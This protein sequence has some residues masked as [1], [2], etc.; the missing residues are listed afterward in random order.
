[1]V[2]G[3]GCAGECGGDWVISQEMLNEMVKELCAKINADIMGDGAARPAHGINSL[4]LSG[5]STYPWLPSAPL[6]PCTLDEMKGLT[7][8]YSP[9]DSWP[10]RLI[11]VEPT[12]IYGPIRRHRRRRIQK[13]WLKRYGTG[14]VGYEYPM[15]DNVLVDQKRGV[16]YCHPRAARW[17]RSQ[18]KEGRWPGVIG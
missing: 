18:T 12:P 2:G 17:I 9:T 7:V 8:G 1:M 3:K 6:T 14:I 11:E 15:G 16:G 13:K 10:V 4:P 5:Y